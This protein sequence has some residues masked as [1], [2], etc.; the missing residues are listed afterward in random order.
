MTYYRHGKREPLIAMGTQHRGSI[1]FCIRGTPLSIGTIQ[2]KITKICHH[3][4]LVQ[5]VDPETDQQSVAWVHAAFISA[6]LRTLCPMLLEG[7]GDS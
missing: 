6:A 5:K 2:L 3:Q 1:N 4:E 7:H